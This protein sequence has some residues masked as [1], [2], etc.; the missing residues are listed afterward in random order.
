[1]SFVVNGIGSVSGITP[2]LVFESLLPT[3]GGSGAW[4]VEKFIRATNFTAGAVVLNL[5]N[6]PLSAQAVFLDY[7]GQKK[8]LTD[9][10]TVSGNNV[11]IQ[12]A[13]P[14]VTDYDA[15]AEFHIQYQY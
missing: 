8:R 2:V 13:D 11:T 4:A 3:P 12:F 7:N 6:I 10:F 1:M 14:Y 15:P 5:V 9:D